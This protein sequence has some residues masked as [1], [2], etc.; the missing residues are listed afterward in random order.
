LDNLA[1]V[2]GVRVAGALACAVLLQALKAVCWRSFA[3]ALGY[4]LRWRTAL[5]VYLAGQW[6][7]LV[8][9]A[10]LS[11]VAMAGR[12]G[13][14]YPTAFAVGVAAAVGELG[15]LT[16]TALVVSLWQVAYL[17]VTLPLACVIAAA[18]WL[19]G[20]EGGVVGRVEAMLPARYAALRE[21]WAHSLRDRTRTAV[22]DGAAVVARYATAVQY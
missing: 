13:V 1:N 8:R 4:P 21:R 9:G 5:A 14:P 6:F 12:F 22:L 16:L 7:I 2:D 10:G 20:T 11:R 17:V 18:I 15:G 19:L 3:A